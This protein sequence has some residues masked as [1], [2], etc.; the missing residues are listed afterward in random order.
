MGLP[1]REGGIHGS[2]VIATW[3]LCRLPCVGMLVDR[4]GLE[5]KRAARQARS[6]NAKER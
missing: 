3:D 6:T 1:F 5:L 2:G 4:C